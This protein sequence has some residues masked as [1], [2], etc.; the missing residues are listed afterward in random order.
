MAAPTAASAGGPC[1]LRQMR[2]RV[3][4]GKRLLN[5]PR[6]VLEAEQLAV[7]TLLRSRR[8]P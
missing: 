8:A 6:L 5:L 3:T 1:L 7:A 4:E 2:T